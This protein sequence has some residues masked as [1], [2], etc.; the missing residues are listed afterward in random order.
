[1]E[2]NYAPLR[3]T[4]YEDWNLVKKASRVNLE[5][6][7]LSYEQAALRSLYRTIEQVLDD[8]ASKPKQERKAEEQ[9]REQRVR[10]MRDE[11]DDI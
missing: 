10:E 4:V 11:G 2:E 5:E 8:E 7:Y 1:M 9:R 3:T 6:N